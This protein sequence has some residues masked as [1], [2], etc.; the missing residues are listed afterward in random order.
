VLCGELQRLRNEYKAALDAYGKTAGAYVGGTDPSI[1]AGWAAASAVSV[2]LLRMREELERHIREHGCAAESPVN[3]KTES[4]DSGARKK[5]R[6]AVM[7]V[8]PPDQGT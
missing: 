3:P 6:P 7:R 8:H 5:I 1:D 2:R 4:T